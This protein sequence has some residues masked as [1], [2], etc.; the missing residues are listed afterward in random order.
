MKTRKFVY[1]AMV[2]FAAITSLTACEEEEYG[3]APK[4]GSI[5][6]TNEN[7]R[8]GDTLTLSVSIKEPGN[9]CYKAKYVW[10]GDN[11]NFCKTVDMLDPL[12]E[13]PTVKFV[14]THSGNIY[15]SLD[16]TFKLSVMS[17][18]GQV[19]DYASASG[20]IKVNP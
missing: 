6:C 5:Y 2:A 1:A 14:P 11:G 15:F 16:V 8:V 12:L 18:G 13:A 9:R 17:Q 20:T 19:S 10:K 4:Y 3:Y 7:P